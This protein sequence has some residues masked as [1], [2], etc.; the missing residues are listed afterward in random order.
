[1][2]RNPD[3]T[4]VARATS[5]AL[6]KCW[7]DPAWKAA[8]L[9]KRKQTVRRDCTTLR[10]N[11]FRK[12]VAYGHISFEKWWTLNRKQ[13]ATFCAAIT[14]AKQF[15]IPAATYLKMTQSERYMLTRNY[16]KK[17][18]GSKNGK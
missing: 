16:N 17:N 9:A 1:M 11:F 4:S 10:L 2:S 14:K 7:K 3:Y 15:G 18:K 12:T 5:E 13:K 6:K 8:V